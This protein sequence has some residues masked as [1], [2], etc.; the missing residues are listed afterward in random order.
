M[1]TP[2]PPQNPGPYGQQP[3]YGQQAPYG[4]QQ[5]Y[6]QQAPGPYGSPYPPQ[7]PYPQQQ[8]YPAQPQY[9]G[10]GAP[11]MAPPPKKRRVGLVLGIVGGVVAGGIALLLVIGTVAESGFPAAKNKLT[12]PHTL[13]DGKYTLAEDLSGTE[14]KKIEDEADGAWDAKDIHAA[15]GR[16]SPD[17]DNTQGMLLVSGMYGRFKNES[18]VRHNMLKGAAEADSVTVEESAQDVTPSGADTTVSCQV[19]TQKQSGTTITYPVCSWADGNTAAIVGEVSLGRKDPGDVDLDAAAR[20]TL[21]IRS[22][23]LR[24]VG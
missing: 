3:P 12:L 10:W 16:Y 7:Q 11:P 20:K 23:M 24:P 2:P 1:S 4:Q 6:G 21:T 19:L 22:E 13:L 9:P 8:P 17:G 18:E 5:P 14:G 15:V